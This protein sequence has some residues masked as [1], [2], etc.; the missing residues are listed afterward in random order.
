M[1]I[2]TC[3]SNLRTITGPGNVE[4]AARVWLLQCMWPLAARH[5]NT[6]TVR[7]QPNVAVT[8]V[9]TVPQYRDCSHEGVQRPADGSW[10]GADVCSLPPWSIYQ[11]P[12]IRWTTTCCCN[13]SSG[14][15]SACVAQHSS[16]PVRSYPSGRTFRLVYDDVMSF[17]VDVMC[18]VLQGSVLGPLFFILYMADHAHW[19][20]KYGVSLHANADDTQLYLHFNRTEIAS[21]VEQPDRCVLDI[22]HWMPSNANRLKLN[23]DKTELLFASSSYSCSTLSG[24]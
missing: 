16:G 13:D 20:A 8:T 18:S 3:T 4:N 24:R 22:G 2:T 19:V 14:V 21:S 23:A 15:S 7:L 11:L 12:L 6:C 17:I 5:R 1:A 10:S 9:V